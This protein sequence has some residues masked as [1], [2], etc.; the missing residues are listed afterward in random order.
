MF[1]FFSVIYSAAPLVCCLQLCSSFSCLDFYYL[2]K[3]GP[4]QEASMVRR[5]FC[6]P[7]WL[8]TAARQKQN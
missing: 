4:G 2:R 1:P 3:P 5:C 8:L 7:H 6:L